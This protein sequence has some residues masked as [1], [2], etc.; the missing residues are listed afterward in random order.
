MQVVCIAVCAARRTCGSPEN[1]TM[2]LGMSTDDA[3]RDLVLVLSYLA[4]RQLKTAEV[5]G[6]L[7]MSRSTYY[8][9]RDKGTLTSVEHLMAAVCRW[10]RP[11]RRCLARGRESPNGDPRHPSLVSYFWCRRRPCRSRPGTGA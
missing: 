10:C 3:D 6:A 4:K 9:Q 7:G 8:E 11:P 5:M 2:V 1:W